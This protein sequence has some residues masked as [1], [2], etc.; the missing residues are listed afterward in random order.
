MSNTLTLNPSGTEGCTPD[1]DPWQPT[2]SGPVTI[3]NDS[4]Y[5]QLLS[6]INNGLLNPSPHGSITVLKAGWTG[7]VGNKKGTYSFN[8]GLGSRG[9]R[10]GTI[11]PS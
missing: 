3:A 11:D 5:D 8:D 9:V 4:G 1:Q 7:T 6:N 2:K 10:K